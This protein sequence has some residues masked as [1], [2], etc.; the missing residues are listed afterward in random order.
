MTQTQQQETSAGG[1]TS[2]G[3]EPPAGAVPLSALAVGDW[4]VPV[5]VMHFSGT[6]DEAA[7]TH[8]G[9]NLEHTFFKVEARDADGRVRF[10]VVGNDIGNGHNMKGEA[11]VVR[12]DAQYSMPLEEFRTKTPQCSFAKLEVGATFR[13]VHRREGTP[14]V[15]RKMWCGHLM[16]HEPDG[17]RNA[18]DVATGTWFTVEFGDDVERVAQEPAPEQ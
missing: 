11:M 1:T 5:R 17:L 16:S 15:Y 6:Y 14:A 12:T 9:P 7:R 13:F 8:K 3:N 4:F 10:N 18:V 2:V